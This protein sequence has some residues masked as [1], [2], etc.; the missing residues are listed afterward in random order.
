MQVMN[1]SKLRLNLKGRIQRGIS[2]THI[3]SKRSK[4]KKISQ[5]DELHFIH[6]SI[7][8]SSKHRKFTTSRCCSFENAK[9][10]INN[11]VREH[12]WQAG[13]ETLCTSHFISPGTGPLMSLVSHSARVHVYCSLPLRNRFLSHC[14]GLSDWSG[15]LSLAWSLVG[16]SA[17][18]GVT[19]GVA[20]PPA[21]EAVT[22]DVTSDPGG[23]A[24]SLLS[25]APLSELAAGG[26]ELK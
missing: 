9:W 23:W 1:Y 17:A 22:S 20:S 3:R 21:S 16:A 13:H 5:A 10:I 19:L 14:A 8:L 24:W 2:N 12:T 6:Y 7:S 18:S 15:L 4:S 26:A 25:A 11:T